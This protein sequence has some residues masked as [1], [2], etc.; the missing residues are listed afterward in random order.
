MNFKKLTIFIFSVATIFNSAAMELGKK[1]HIPKVTDKQIVRKDSI[2]ILPDEILSHILFYLISHPDVKNARDLARGLTNFEGVCKRFQKLIDCP[3]LNN[4][5]TKKEIFHLM[6][7]YYQNLWAICKQK[8]N[9]DLSDLNEVFKLELTKES[10]K[11]IFNN[12]MKS[13]ADELS[14]NRNDLLLKFIHFNE[15][16][17]MKDLFSINGVSNLRNSYHGWTILMYAM[18]NPCKNIVSLLLKNG[19][20]PQVNAQDISGDTALIIAVKYGALEKV[21]ELL[22]IKEI[23]LKIKNLEKKTALD[24]VQ[25]QSYYYL[26]RIF[27][28]YRVNAELVKKSRAIATAIK[29]KMDEQEEKANFERTIESDYLINFD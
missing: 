26:P 23:N 25:W 18:C 13:L 20:S 6:E 1:A 12:F 8:H 29:E 22:K 10:I 9:I 24:Y 3:N 16:D 7:S 2:L 15:E 5:G 4:S 17:E 14:Y 11:S 27:W 19:Y 21:Q 28:D